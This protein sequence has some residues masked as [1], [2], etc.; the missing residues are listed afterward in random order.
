MNGIKIQ[1]IWVKDA[2]SD[3]NPNVLILRDRKKVVVLSCNPEGD[4][5]RNCWFLR[6]GH[7]TNAI[8]VCTGTYTEDP[9]AVLEDL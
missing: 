9:S 2:N 7:C 3:D 6:N 8:T 4:V 5:C 1:S